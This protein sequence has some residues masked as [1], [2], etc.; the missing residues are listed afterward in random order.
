[1]VQIKY[2]LQML[3]ME[4]APLIESEV[5]RNSFVWLTGHPVEPGQYKDPIQLIPIRID[6]FF[7]NP[8]S[9]TSGHL[10]PLD[11][12]GRHI[13]ENAYLMLQRSNQ[14]QGNM[15]LAELL[16]LLENILRRHA[17]KPV[18]GSRLD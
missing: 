2:Y 11:R 9:I 6:D 13:P 17:S 3:S 8:R 16:E 4:G 14:L 5:V 7:E 10:I 15:T 12:G 18:K 1:M